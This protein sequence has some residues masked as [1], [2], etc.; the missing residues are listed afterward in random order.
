MPTPMACGVRP[1]ARRVRHR[2]REVGAG[3]RWKR[4]VCAIP[5]AHMS[6]PALTVPTTAQ[7][8]RTGAFWLLAATLGLLLFASS[9]PSPLYVVYQQEWGFSSIVLTSVFAVYAL[10]LLA[11][12][13][14]A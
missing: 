14:V 13:L 11:S 5:S 6:S 12:L 7:L 3:S 8:G 9:A 10:A 1:I 4:R 2:P